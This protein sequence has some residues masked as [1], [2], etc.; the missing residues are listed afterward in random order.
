L[1][2]IAFDFP[3]RSFIDPVYV[4]RHALFGKT[5]LRAGA[6][7]LHVRC[8]SARSSKLVRYY[9][10]FEASTFRIE[11]QLN[12]RFL[13]Q[14]RINHT[15]DFAKLATILPVR[16]IH[17]ASLDEAKLRKQLL[18]SGL[19]QPRRDEIGKGVAVRKHSLWV[20]LRYLRQNAKLTNVRRLQTPLGSTNTL[21]ANA[22][23]DWARQWSSAPTR[24]NPHANEMQQIRLS[25]NAQVQKQSSTQEGKK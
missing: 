5:R 10:K 11:L 13:R 3:I 19:S 24:L 22:L 18:R 25:G 6:N 15:S 7:E 16:H 8:G 23:K 17:F 4:R 20:T 21:V 9:A 12:A 1:V 2:E 14:H